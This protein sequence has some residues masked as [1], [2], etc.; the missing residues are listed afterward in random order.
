MD[1]YIFII[2]FLSTSISIW[3]VTVCPNDLEP[4]IENSRNVE[5]V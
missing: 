5:H 4:V 3:E 1:E 2:N